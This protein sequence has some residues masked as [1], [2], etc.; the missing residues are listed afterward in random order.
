M[1]SLL[2]LR[3]L[4]IAGFKSFA[5]PVHIELPSGIAAL[6]GPNGSGKSNVVDA[7]RW[8]L[9][10]QSMRDL[11]GQKA[12][13]II[14]AG[15]RRSLG[16]AEVSLSFETNDS[17]DPISHLTVTRR[18]YRSGES[19][20]V[21]DRQKVRL[22]DLVDALRNAGID[23]SRQVVVNQGMADALL[24]ASPLERRLAIEQAAGLEGYRARRDE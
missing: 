20:Y 24:A 13:D 17:A 3:S 18:L 15:P 7:V 8:C 9:G 1:E 21:V 19:E 14:H 16:S 2:F 12:E 22:R 5:R 11:R 6:V 10:E 4:D 23:S